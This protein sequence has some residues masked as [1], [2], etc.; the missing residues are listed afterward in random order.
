[1]LTKAEYDSAKESALTCKQLCRWFADQVAIY[2]GR[3]HEGLRRK[4]PSEVWMRRWPSLAKIMYLRCRVIFEW[5]FPPI[6]KSPIKGINGASLT[7]VEGLQT[8]R[9][10]TR[11]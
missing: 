10:E 1:M 5:I 4:T 3:A 8:G 9:T 7:V 6:H 11:F 2:H